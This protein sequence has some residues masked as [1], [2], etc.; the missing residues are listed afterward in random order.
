MRNI[1]LYWIAKVLYFTSMVKL[2]TI[3]NIC[4]RTKYQIEECID[5]HS[6]QI[7]QSSFNMALESIINEFLSQLTSLYAGSMKIFTFK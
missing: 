1:A 7:I 3:R 2:F 4:Q 5:F 6:F